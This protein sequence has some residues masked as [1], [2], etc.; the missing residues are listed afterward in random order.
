MSY[1]LS[2]WG[3]SNDAAGRD[4]QPGNTM[5]Q[6]PPHAE[7]AVRA[8][9]FVSVSSVSWLPVLGSLWGWLSDLAGKELVYPFIIDHVTVSSTCMA[10]DASG[11][12]ISSH[13]RTAAVCSFCC[14]SKFA[15]HWK[16]G[17]HVVTKEAIMLVCSPLLFTFVH[18]CVCRC[19]RHY[20]GR[21]GNIIHR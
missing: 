16:T 9:A 4:A 14:E 20:I 12:Q 10:L 19:L 18:V 17:Y 8:E 15:W 5:N 3:V 7:I 6:G 21:A 13:G 1:N 11:L 2:N